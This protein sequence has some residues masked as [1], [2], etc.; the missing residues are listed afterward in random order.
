MR[1]LWKGRTVAQYGGTGVG[2][3]GRFLRRRGALTGAIHGRAHVGWHFG[4]LFGAALAAL[5]KQF[6]AVAEAEF[7]QRLVSG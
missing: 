5:G 4:E 2:R 6:A 7:D 3:R 1:R